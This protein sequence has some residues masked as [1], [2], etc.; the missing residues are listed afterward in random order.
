M[1]TNRDYEGI[2]EIK[3]SCVS[4]KV[5]TFNPR[6]YLQGTFLQPL[7]ICVSTVAQR[8]AKVRQIKG[9]LHQGNNE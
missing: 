1:A 3:R 8:S 9:L 7:V 4:T 5:I 6:D 2:K